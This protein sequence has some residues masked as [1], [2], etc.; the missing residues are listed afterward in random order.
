[1]HRLFFRLVLLVAVIGLSAC[2]TPAPDATRARLA[3]LPPVDVILLGEQHDADAHHQLQREVVGQLAATRRLAALAM[4]MAEQGRDTRSLPASASE[5][6]VQQA[7]GWNDQAWPWARYGPVAM[8]AVRA[9]VPVLGANLP[10]AAMRNAMSDTSLDGQLPGPALKAQQQAI[11]LG[12]C[13]LLPES[14]ITPMTRIQ[15]ARDRAMADTV[16]AAARE[17]QVV[18]LVAGAGHVDRSLGV[19]RHLPAALRLQAVRLQAG[20]TAD[21]IGV[22]DAT[23]HTPALPEQDHC[24]SLRPAG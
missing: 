13:N 2:A 5:A 11:R 19:P 20:E 21:R 10:R 18:V 4:E 16:R 9:G 1:M 3:A 7:L 24:A 22:F 6:Q 14:Q 23:W 8:A 17:G 15:I 12:H